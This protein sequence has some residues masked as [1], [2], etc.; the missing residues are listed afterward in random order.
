MS[1]SNRPSHQSQLV[2]MRMHLEDLPQPDLEP[3]YQL[4]HY[5]PGDEAGWNSLI[6]ECFGSGYD[7]DTTLGNDPLFLPE[8]VLFIEHGNEIIA[9]ASAW[10]TPP[11][12]GERTGVVHM[13]AASPRHAGHRLG[14]M[15]SLAVLH[16][17]VSEGV[18]HAV[19]RTDDFRLPAIATYLKL[20]FKPY[21]DSLD[22]AQRWHAIYQN[23]K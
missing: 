12:W 13:V 16:R 7:F 11:L 10:R 2:M 22:H 15:V 14:Y 18:Q 4:R 8:R 1:H 20:G 19:L 5:A 9:T 3:G 23:L 21:L 6:G 17:F